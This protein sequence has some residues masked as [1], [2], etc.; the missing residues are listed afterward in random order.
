VIDQRRRRRSAHA[1]APATGYCNNRHSTTLAEEKET[2][3]IG[4]NE[5]SRR[6][7]ARERLREEL[8]RY[9]AVSAYLYVC[10][11]A[12]LLYKA[13]ILSTAG[14]HFLPLGLAAGKALILGKFVLLGEA[15]GVGTRLHARTVL[16]RIVNNSVLFLVVLVV[17]TAV[18]EIVVGLV[19]GE[20]IS[21]AVTAI[22]D[23]PVLESMASCLL[24][25]L[26]LVPLVTVTEL[27]RVLGPGRLRQLLLGPS[28]K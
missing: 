19:H 25:L 10:F 8:Q 15:A 9:L 16:Q 12:I 17:L 6:P 7:G 3:V 26:V 21:Q 5:S 1:G 24:M 11:A 20:S 23:R 14:E 2:N 4:E 18:E 13:A 27:G 22:G 28:S